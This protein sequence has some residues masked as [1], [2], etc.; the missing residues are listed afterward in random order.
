MILPREDKNREYEANINKY[1]LE[2][3][4]FW[5]EL[6]E[7]S[8][9]DH[10]T[11]SGLNNGT[12]SPILETGKIRPAATVIVDFFGVDFSDIFPRYFCEFSK[13]I[14]LESQFVSAFMQNQEELTMD[15][16]DI[17]DFQEL[18]VAVSNVLKKLSPRHSMILRKRFFEGRTFE[19]LS[20]EFNVS[21]SRIRQINLKAVN[22]LRFWYKEELLTFV[23]RDRRT[24]RIHYEIR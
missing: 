16:A 15:V 8:G 12:Y 6:V 17:Y 5:R 20:K 1:R 13:G 2:N 11:L 24:F 7:L 23:K 4:L 21:R 9:V 10:S 14:V 18:N 19:E 3:N 22:D